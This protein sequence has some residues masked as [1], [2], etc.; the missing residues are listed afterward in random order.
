[1]PWL[2]AVKMP[3]AT[4]AKGTVCGGL[5][6]PPAVTTTVAELCP[7]SSSGICTLS[8]PGKEENR[9][10]AIPLNVTL[11]PPSVISSLPLVPTDENGFC[12]PPFKVVPKMAAMLPRAIGFVPAANVVL[13]T[14]LLGGDYRPCGVDAQIATLQRQQ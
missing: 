6:S 4:A 2:L 9:G 11:A 8:W 5:D 13:L 3:G 10:A 12:D 1:M 14:T 7:A